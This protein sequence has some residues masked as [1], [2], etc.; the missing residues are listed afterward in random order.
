[1]AG[2]TCTGAAEN[3]PVW[4]AL[5]GI[6]PT[7]LWVVLILATTFWFRRE[8]S[9]LLWHFARQI[10]HGAGFKLA[11]LEIGRA[12]VQPGS[13]A[14]ISGAMGDVRVDEGGARHQERERYY[15][16]SRSLMLVH[17]IAPSTKPGQLYDVILYLVIHPR[18]EAT[19]IAVHKVEYY[20]GKS[21]GRGIF[22]SHDRARAFAIATSA[23]GPFMCTAAIHFVDGDVVTVSRYVDFEM[24]AVGPEPHAVGGGDRSVR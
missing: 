2:A 5:T 1:M 11:G 9:S 4:A 6:G 24:G 19:L 10:R 15:K 13:D 3:N 12:Y 7:L 14:T 16:P 22:T 17:R 18:S 8:L 21:W 20:F 23:Y